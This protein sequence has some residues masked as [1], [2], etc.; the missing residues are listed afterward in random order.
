VKAKKMSQRINM[1]VIARKVKME[2]LDRLAK[3]K[4]QT[5]KKVVLVKIMRKTVKM[6]LKEK[7]KMMM[8]KKKERK[9]VKNQMRKM[10]RL[11]KN[12]K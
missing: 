7:M 1:P 8:R 4:N 11:R 6:N 2:S 10:F 9:K 12:K 3:K 5:K